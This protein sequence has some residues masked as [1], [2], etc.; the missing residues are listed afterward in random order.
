[1]PRNQTSTSNVAFFLS[2]L[3]TDHPSPLRA[4]DAMSRLEAQLRQQEAGSDTTRH[5]GLQT[6]FPPSAQR[7]LV[8]IA[9][10][11]GKM[12]VRCGLTL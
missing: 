7:V 11:V 1:M 10:S 12:L 9:A 4:R 8:Q 3:Q 6:D 2:P 5:L